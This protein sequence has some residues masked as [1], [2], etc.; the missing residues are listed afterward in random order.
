MNIE[1]VLVQIVLAF[2]GVVFGFIFVQMLEDAPA[3]LVLKQ[4]P[5]TEAPPPEAFK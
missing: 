2:W 3:F 1:F 5:P 4:E